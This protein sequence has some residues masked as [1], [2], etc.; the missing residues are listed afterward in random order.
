MTRELLMI[1]SRF[2]LC[3]TRGGNYLMGWNLKKKAIW[4]FF[5]ILAVGK[6]KERRNQQYKKVANHS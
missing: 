3:M 1:S 2:N 4:E 6:S 5:N